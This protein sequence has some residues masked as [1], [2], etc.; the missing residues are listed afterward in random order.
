MPKIIR[1]GISLD[2]DLLK[3]F[4]SLINRKNYTNR[5]EA[6]RDL[7]RESLVKDEWHKNVEVTGAIILVY[8]H[9]KRE[10]LNSL[11]D[12]QHDYHKNIISTQH[13]HL[14]HNNCLEIIA[15][16]GLSKT[17]EGLFTRLKSLKGVKYANFAAATTGKD[18]H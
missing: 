11:M 13:L 7:I 3:K 9:H 2:E 1:F 17:I 6:I 15:T 5:S 14:D 18:V 10:V 4:D 16:K 12:I 8:D